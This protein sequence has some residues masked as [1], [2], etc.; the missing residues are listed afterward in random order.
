MTTAWDRKEALK[1]A[2]RL[3]ALY[4]SPA[5]PATVDAAALLRAAD[6]EIDRLRA[7]AV[8]RDEAA[9]KA[10]YE[11]TRRREVEANKPDYETLWAEQA[12][13]TEKL[14]EAAE[15]MAEALRRIRPR[16]EKLVRGAIAW[17]RPETLAEVD[18]ALATWNASREGGE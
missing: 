12:E 10:Q 8:A 3:E 11:L 7:E 13:R 9:G 16:L 1:V 14:E 4:A 18:A 15:K 6:A 17:E 5:M 2:E